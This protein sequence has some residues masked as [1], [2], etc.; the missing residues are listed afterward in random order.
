MLAGGKCPFLVP[1]PFL[2]AIPF[3]CH[4]CHLDP[5]PLDL[6][7]GIAPAGAAPGTESRPDTTQGPKAALALQPHC[8]P[9]PGAAP[10]DIGVRVSAPTSCEWSCTSSC[11]SLGR[12]RGS[13]GGVQPWPRPLLP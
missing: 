12:G 3:L 11:H 2:V 13:L 4:W 1:Y 9:S 8:F 10:G 5:A 7:P 6:S